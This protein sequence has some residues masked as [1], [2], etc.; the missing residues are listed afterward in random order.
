MRN[1]DTAGQGGWVLTT[2]FQTQ[3]HLGSVKTQLEEVHNGER[4]RQIPASIFRI[5]H[6]SQRRRWAGRTSFLFGQ[7]VAIF[8]AIDFHYLRYFL[9]L[10]RAPSGGAKVEVYVWLCKVAEVG[11]LKYFSSSC[12]S[13]GIVYS[14][15]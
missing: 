5:V 6:G 10:R 1:G 11:Y 9:G 2:I 14:I 4:E 3:K 7:S 15:I 8:I 13:I 12:S